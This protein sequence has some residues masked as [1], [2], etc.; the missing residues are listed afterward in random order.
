MSMSLYHKILDDYALM[1]G[2]GLLL[3]PVV[4]DLLL[5]PK[6]SDRVSVLKTYKT[7]TPVSVSTNAIA[8]EN[9]SDD[10]LYEI[11]NFFDRIH[12]S[13]YGLDEVEYKT[14]TTRSFYIKAV[15]GIKKIIGLL[16]DK[17]RLV[18]SFRL[19]RNRDKHELDYDLFILQK[20]LIF[21]SHGY[22]G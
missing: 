3:T 1:S 6:F 16:E 9:Y 18:L 10:S 13:V 5:D 8:L 2:G 21:Y 22:V 14:M 11:V 19:L 7:I 15:S 20:M 12:I 17:S 4:G